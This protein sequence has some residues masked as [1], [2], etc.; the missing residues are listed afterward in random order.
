MS[1]L[2][3]DLVTL[4]RGHPFVLGHPPARRSRPPSR[5]ASSAINRRAAA[6]SPRR[7]PQVR[8]S[9][10]ARFLRGRGRRQAE[11]SR[12]SETW[13]RQAR[14][15][16]LPAADRESGFERPSR[17]SVMNVHPLQAAGH[18]RAVRREDETATRGRPGRRSGSPSSASAG[19]GEG[20]SRRPSQHPVLDQV[21]AR[22][23]PVTDV[24]E[25]V[26]DPAMNAR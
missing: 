26:G 15:C 10:L 6:S 7:G 21:F 2:R 5:S 14:G 11:R 19:G 17:F 8:S 12:R 23:A 9:S 24:K 3:A 20:R 18:Q 25:H 13:S 4:T 22:R 16:S 1:F